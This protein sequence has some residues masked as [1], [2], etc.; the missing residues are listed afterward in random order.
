[1]DSFIGQKIRKYQIVSKLGAG[2]MGSV[3]KAMDTILEREVALKLLA[4]TLASDDSF[5]ERFRLEA[6]SLAR[7]DHSNIVKVYDADWDENKLFIVMEYVDGGSLADLIKQEGALPTALVIKLLQQTASG[8]D[9]AHQRGLIHR[10]IKPANVLID[11][12]GN[13]KLTDFGL[14]KDTDTNLTA[15]GMR[16]GTPAYMAPEQIQGDEVT[17]ALDIYAL[18]IVTY[19]MLTGRPPFQGNMS[20]IFEGHLLRQLPPIHQINPNIPADAQDVLVRVMAKNPAERYAS[21]SNF[22]QAMEESLHLSERPSRAAT[23]PITVVQTGAPSSGRVSPSHAGSGEPGTSR[24]RS[25]T[26]PAPPPGSGAYPPASRPAPPGSGPV[27]RSGPV[28]H[29]TSGQYAPEKKGGLGGFLSGL[30]IGAVGVVLILVLGVLC[31]CGGLY[32]VGTNLPDSTPTSTITP[33]PPTDTPIPTPIPTEEPTLAPTDTPLPEPTESSSV[34]LFQDDFSDPDTAGW[35]QNQD[36]DG[37]TDYEQGGYRF[38]INKVDWIFWSNPELSFTDVRVEVDVTKQGGPDSNEFGIICRYVD[39]DNFYF[40]TATSDGYYSISKY[41]AGE[42]IPL[43]EEAFV[44]TDLVNQGNAV[45]HLRADCLGNT[46]TLYINGE[47]VDSVTDS[48]YS[49]G[50]VGLL[51]GSY[52]E[53]GAD[54]LFDNFIAYQP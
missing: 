37:I 22:V 4:P 6:R 10:D 31:L 5:V 3:F 7:L 26:G 21:A 42:Y 51:G 23:P 8:L 53:A 9:Y 14:V 50:D 1:M 13:A 30:G 17:A 54:L 44:E 41:V 11:T 48:D 16:L 33:I 36:S 15:D 20:A 39:V 28:S 52:D 32:M 40:L 43:S 47:F 12:H 38:F 24:A 34:I 45:N 27:S 29:P 18:G 49:S 46:L 19:E 35:T 2:G 25:Q